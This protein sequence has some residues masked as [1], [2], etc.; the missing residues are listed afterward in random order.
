MFRRRT[1]LALTA[2]MAL[3]VSASTASAA[4]VRTAKDSA[5]AERTLV[6]D[7]STP[8]LLLFLGERLVISYR[9]LRGIQFGDIPDTGVAP[10]VDAITDGPDV[11]D[12]MAKNTGL[13]GPMPAQTRAPSP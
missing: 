13:R 7:G 5:I 10:R 11:G 8:S 1:F 2:A 3:V 9:A 12:P 6:L 4:P